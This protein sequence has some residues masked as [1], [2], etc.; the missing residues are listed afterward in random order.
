MQAANNESIVRTDDIWITGVL[1][2]K[3]GIPDSCVIGAYFKADLHTWGFSG[4]D[5]QNKWDKLAAEINKRPHC[6]VVG[7]SV[8]V[9]G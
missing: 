9:A 4:T 3:S 5:M 2:E 8:F 1:R 7:D 6:H